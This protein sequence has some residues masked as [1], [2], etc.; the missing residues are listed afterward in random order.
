MSER[1]YY[2][3]LGVEESASHDEIRKAYRDL[4]L[5]YHPDR[6][7]DAK[8]TDRFVRI[9]EA[10][11]VIS[12]SKRRREYDA[13][14][15][16]RRER[17]KLLEERPKPHQAP[18]SNRS[19][20]PGR[21]P[22]DLAAKTTQAAVLFSQGKFDHAESF[23]RLVLRSDPNRAM[24]H[25]ILGDIA[26]SR[27]DYRGA[28]GHY[29]YAMQIEPQNRTFA[30]RYEE[31]LNLTA[32]FSRYDDVA[33]ATP[34]AAALWVAAV[35]S[36][37]MLFYVAAVREQPFAENLKPVST[38]TFGLIMMLFIN[39]VVAGAAL[40]ITQTVDRFTSVAQGSSG[41]MSPAVALGLVAVASFWA[42]AFLYAFLGLVQKSFTYSVSRAVTTAGV[43]AVSYALMSHFSPSISWEQTLLWGGNLIYIGLLCGW[44]VADAFR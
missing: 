27:Q 21:D 39:G 24:A 9:A 32:T 44:T 11:S 42:S 1:T 15:K 6:S 5:K 26:R 28:L 30:A 16:Y 8:T 7:G 18:P 14:L 41:R 40:A 12:D 13:M 29:S 38:W 17:A 3:E 34:N 2:V 33:P 37:L 23:A 22:G 20:A 4:V 19:K 25:A 36:G 43:L 31:A 10:Y 35:V